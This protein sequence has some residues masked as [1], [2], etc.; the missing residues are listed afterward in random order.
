MGSQL[1]NYQQDRYHCVANATD[2]QLPTKSSRSQRHQLQTQ[3][4]DS[5]KCHAAPAILAETA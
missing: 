5:L 4:Y 2:Y 1:T 3:R